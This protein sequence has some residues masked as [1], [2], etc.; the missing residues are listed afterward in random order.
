M[1]TVDRYL[2]PLAA[3]LLA[4]CVVPLED[5]PVPAEVP[6]PPPP[7]DAPAEQPPD[8]TLAE[9]VRAA[10]ARDE[11][12]RG[13]AI[14]VAVEQGAV[15]LSGDIKTLALRRRATAVA[16]SVPGTRAVDNRLV[17]TG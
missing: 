9:Q 16:R 8:A 1:N 3:C 4:A 17:I 5:R 14:A 12:L 6:A 13:Y 10:L 2:A 11:L 15:I 7:A